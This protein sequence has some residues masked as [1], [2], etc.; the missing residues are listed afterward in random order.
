[1]TDRYQRE[2]DKVTVKV[3]M[4]EGKVKKDFSLVGKADDLQELAVSI[5]EKAQKLVK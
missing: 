2:A 3:V 1:M 4:R 5:L